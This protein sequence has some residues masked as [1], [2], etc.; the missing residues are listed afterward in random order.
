MRVYLHYE[1]PLGPSH[2]KRVTIKEG[3]VLLATD[4]LAAF[5]AS[6][7]QAHCSASMATD[8]LKLTCNGKTVNLGAPL[9]VKDKSDLNVEPLV[10]SFSVSVASAAALVPAPAPKTAATTTQAPKAALPA[11]A[12]VEA[13]KPAVA[14]P[15][16]TKPSS[17]LPAAAAPTDVS[18][19][20]SAGQC[21]V[22][23]AEL[24]A[25]GRLREARLVLERGLLQE[26]NHAPSL[27]ALGALA[28]RKGDD[29][30]AAERFGRAA[31]AY[32]RPSGGGGGATAAA[33]GACALLGQGKALCKLGDLGRALACYQVAPAPPPPPRTGC[34]S[35]RPSCSRGPCPLPQSPKACSQPLIA[36]PQSPP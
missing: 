24:S 14:K 32:Q 31:E 34:G 15:A 33:D 28:A 29:L 35:L 36:S 2:T 1:G 22:A 17:K 26:P 4:V 9:V 12:K 30:E 5:V 6:Y 13:A 18:T 25:K 20:A 7:N 23:A 19:A 11:A 8:A 10:G 27:A 21:A 16:A 3:E